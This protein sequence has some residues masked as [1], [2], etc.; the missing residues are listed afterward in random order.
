MTKLTC[1]ICGDEL[2][3]SRRKFCKKCSP[4]NRKFKVCQICGVQLR[5]YDKKFCPICRKQSISNY[6]Y[7]YYRANKDKWDSNMLNLGSGNLSEHRLVDFDA[8]QK[9]V[10]DEI[11]T[12]KIPRVV[13]HLI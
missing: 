8:E 4:E 2:T 7:E 11:R 9:R 12:L 6:N 13:L 3:G 5:K 1:I 10:S